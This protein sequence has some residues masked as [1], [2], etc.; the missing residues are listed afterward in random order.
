[1]SIATLGVLE[2]TSK[3]RAELGGDGVVGDDL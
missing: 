1:M 2:N 3:D